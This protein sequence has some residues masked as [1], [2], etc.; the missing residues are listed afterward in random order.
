MLLLGVNSGCKE[1]VSSVYD[2]Y[3]CFGLAFKIN[4]PAR[5]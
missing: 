5:L 4:Q 1:V 3:L 2:L